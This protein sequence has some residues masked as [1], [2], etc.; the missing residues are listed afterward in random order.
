MKTI[1]YVIVSIALA[2]L[3]LFLVFNSL[4]QSDDKT[5][6][7]QITQDDQ[8]VTD[9]IAMYSPEIR[10]NIFTAAMYPEIIV[11]LNEMKK[12]TN[13]E[14]ENLL[15][16]FNKDEQEK[17]WNL[18]RYPD[19]ISELAA[20]NKKTKLEV[21]NIT[22]QYPEDIQKIALEEETNNHDILVKIDRNSKKYDS[23]FEAMLKNYPPSAVKSFKELIK[24]PEILSTLSENLQFTVL[25]GDIYKKN[26]ELVK[27]KTD[28]LNAALQKKSVQDA[29]DWE[30]SMNSNPK[31]KQQFEQAAI[32]YAKENGYTLEDTTRLATNAVDR[33]VYSYNWWFGYPSW[34]P[35]AYWYPYP[36][37]Y[38]WGFYYG[39]GRHMI[40]FGLPS[41]YFLNW[42]FYHPIHH[43]HYP[44]LSGHYYNYYYGHRTSVGYNSVARSVDDWQQRNSD[45]VTNAW[46]NDP[47][48]RVQLF[49]EYGQMESERAKYNIV[50]PKNSLER[51]EYLKMNENKYPNIKTVYANRPPVQK[52]V[53][54]K[55]MREM[56]TPEIR[57]RVS[58]QPD[59][60]KPRPLM[61]PQPN[62]RELNKGQDFHRDTWQQ[63]PTWKSPSIPR[64]PIRTPPSGLRVP[65]GNLRAPAGGVH[66][67]PAGKR[68]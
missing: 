8:K 14:F 4:S 22:S 33:Y 16:P 50:N 28:S 34:Y 19:L 65:S 17:L 7:N 23:S 37:W 61:N 49:K 68:R 60:S 35:Y 58:T 38:D 6:L 29:S 55:P 53:F 12:K 63:M 2:C 13:D 32:E 46:N 20:G 9:A 62:F 51:G 44:D 40:F 59:V 24:L 43:Y 41:L 11:R 67:P 27:R 3:A 57:P 21:D 54:E 36:Y 10:N 39:P 66:T 26:P 42:Y 18:T 31:A 1:S 47:A 30:N 52:D 15:K 25:V 64:E 56:S 45:V 48:T 5:L